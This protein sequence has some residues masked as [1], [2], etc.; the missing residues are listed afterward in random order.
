MQQYSIHN[1]N[2]LSILLLLVISCYTNLNARESRFIIKRAIVSSDKNPLYLDFWPIVAKA[3]NRM[4]I[5][6]TLA[7]IGDGDIEVDE[8]LGDVIRLN[9]I[10]GVSDGL[11]AQMV[12]LLLPIC[13]DEEICL[14][15]DIDL[16]PISKSYYVD[17]VKGFSPDML[18]MYR[19]TA[20]SPEMKRYAMCYIAAQGSL[21][22]EIFGIYCVEDIPKLIK[23]WADIK[24]GF[25]T[26]EKL[27]YRYLRAW[28]NFEKQTVKLGE[29]DKI[30]AY[31]RIDRAK[32]GY[33]AERLLFEDSYIDCHC[34]RPYQKY[35]SEIDRLMFLI[36]M[37]DY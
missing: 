29:S 10:P 20:Y 2:F 6:P 27:L 15:S 12:R 5:K 32:W 23:K 34:I 26:D 16:I 37:K 17:R 3:W 4:G 11:Y 35:K 8:T 9:S 22:K 36:E 33:D 19:D 7:L 25:E 21:F 31:T 1:I 30:S 18:V 28:G 13:F 24:L 14:L